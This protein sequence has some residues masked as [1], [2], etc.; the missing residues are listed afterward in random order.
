MVDKVTDDSIIFTYSSPDGEEGYPGTVTATAGYTVSDNEVTLL[1]TAI[2]TAP[3]IVNLTNHTY[4]NLKGPGS[5][6]LDHELTLNAQHYTPIDA[7]CLPTGIVILLILL[8]IFDLYR[9]D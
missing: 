9:K 8:V 1:Y 7:H 6:I 2:T 3:T 4:F 5:T